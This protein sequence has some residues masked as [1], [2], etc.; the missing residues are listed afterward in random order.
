MTNRAIIPSLVLADQTQNFTAR[1]GHFDLSN[2]VT[3]SNEIDFRLLVTGA[4][5]NR[6]RR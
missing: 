5:R 1:T 3:L 4:S 6:N 2:D